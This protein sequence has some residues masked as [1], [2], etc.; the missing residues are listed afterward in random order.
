[1]HRKWLSMEAFVFRPNGLESHR[2]AYEQPWSSQGIKQLKRV[3]LSV[4]VISGSTQQL[5]VEY[6]QIQAQKLLCLRS[7]LL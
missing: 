4:I 3:L 6:F 7:T 2:L 5:N 1:M